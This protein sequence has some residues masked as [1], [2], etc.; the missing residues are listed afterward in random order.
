MHDVRW[1][2]GPE[3]TATVPLLVMDAWRPVASRVGALL[4]SSLAGIG[5][6]A[7]GNVY[8]RLVHA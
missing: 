4:P 5:I 2:R 1:I 3:T 8:P 6:T 7:S